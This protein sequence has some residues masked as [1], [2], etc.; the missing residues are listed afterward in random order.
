MQVVSKY[1]S[2]LTQPQDAM[3]FSVPSALHADE[4]CEGLER[5]DA[6]TGSYL[7]SSLPCQLLANNIVLHLYIHPFV[8][9][10]SF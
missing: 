8:T 9:K 6:Q 2:Y 5:R 7:S 3:F 4:A 10:L 1:T